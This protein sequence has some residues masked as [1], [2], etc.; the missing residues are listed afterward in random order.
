VA[1]Q[2]IEE[3]GKG[4]LATATVAAPDQHRPAALGCPFCRFSQQAGLADT[5]LARKG[6]ELCTFTAKLPIERGT[7]VGPPDQGERRLW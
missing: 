3:G 5:R 1:L 7:L 2:E 4:F 6:Q